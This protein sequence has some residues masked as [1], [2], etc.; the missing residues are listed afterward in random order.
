MLIA[1]STLLRGALRDWISLFY[2]I[3]LPVAFLVVLGFIFP[4]PEYQ[5]QLMAGMLGMGVLFFGLNGIAFESLYQRNSGVYKLLRATPYRS[6]TFI[7]N[8][9]AARSVVALFSSLVVLLVGVFVLGVQVNWLDL[10]LVLLLI[11]GVV[12]FTLLGLVVSNLSQNENQVSMLSSLFTMPMIFLG[13]AFY[14]LSAMPGW[15]QPIGRALPLSYLIEGER[16]ILTGNGAGF[17]LPLLILLGFTL[18]ALL[19]A[20]VTFRWDPDDTL[21]RRF[22][23]RRS[24]A[25]PA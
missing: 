14:S 3:V 5:C 17:V 9:T 15:L 11:P 4:S 6:V 13:G 2:A 22:Q 7:A 23:S 16:V 18:L 8:L 10:L 1:F 25:L 20:V 24:N 21:A 19:L 12:C